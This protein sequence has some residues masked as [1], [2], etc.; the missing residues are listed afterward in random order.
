MSIAT[1]LLTLLDRPRL[2]SLGMLPTIFALAAV[3][4]HLCLGQSIREKRVV[5]VAGQN[6]QTFERQPKVAV[7]A[8]VGEY[9]Q[10]SGLSRLRYAAHDADRLSQVLKEQGYRVLLLKEEQ[11]TRGSIEQALRNTGEFVDQSSATVV[12][13]FSGHGFSDKGDNYLATFEAS[14][15]DL[16]G[17]GLP[18]TKVESLLKQTGA[19][20]VM[21]LSTLAETTSGKAPQFLKALRAC[22]LPVVFAGSYLLKLGVSVMKTIS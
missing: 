14:S 7:I 13:F 20:R 12:F 3:T 4:S 19:I 11:A 8:G 18:I 10:L 21:M 2:L 1:N 17:T 6:R 15:T 22:S 5:P 9:T 16:A